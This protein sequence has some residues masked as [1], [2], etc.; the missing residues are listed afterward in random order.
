LRPGA[1][2]GL[3]GGSDHDD[4]YVLDLTKA[5]GVLS[6]TVKTTDGTL[7]ADV[8]DDK[9]NYI[10]EAGSDKN[11]TQAGFY[12]VVLPLNQGGKWYINVSGE[13]SYSLAYTFTQQNDGGSGKDAGDSK[14]NALP[15]NKATI[16]GIMGPN[17][18]DDYYKVQGALGRK[19][20]IRYGAS[21]VSLQVSLYDNNMNFLTN[22]SVDGGKTATLADDTGATGDYYIVVENG[23][24]DYHITISK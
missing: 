10:G 14:E 21:A 20:S 12:D 18:N 13:G 15:V 19:L 7:K 3:L 8:Y 9:R 6:V 17:D 4:Y 2:S 24:G 5:G 22:V 11:Q 23:N 16:D 1:S